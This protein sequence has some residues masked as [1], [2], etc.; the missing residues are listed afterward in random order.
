MTDQIPSNREGNNAPSSCNST[1]HPLNYQ[2][3]LCG[4]LWENI[5]YQY[6]NQSL[7]YTSLHV[8]HQ[9]ATPLSERAPAQLALTT[10]SNPR[11]RPTSSYQ[12]FPASALLGMWT[13]GD[14][15]QTHKWETTHCMVQL[16]VGICWVL[17]EAVASCH[18]RTYT[19]QGASIDQLV[20]RGQQ[21]HT[22]PPAYPPNT[23]L[24][25]Y[26][27]HQHIRHQIRG[28]S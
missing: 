14:P 15:H 6:N 21:Q 9:I 24:Q 25:T 12:S 8:N 10:A 3:E 18:L 17:L 23:K 11:P 16:L 19:I 7:A 27:P 26:N 22:I 5:E 1:T 20:G 4:P 13:N 28:S 2:A